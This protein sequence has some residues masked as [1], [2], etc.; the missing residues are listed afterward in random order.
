M[1]TCLLLTALLAPAASAPGQG[2][3]VFNNRLITGGP[4]GSLNEAFYAPIYGVN[5]ADPTS[6]RTGQGNAAGPG[7]LPIPLGT[8][9]YSGHPLLAGTGFTAQLW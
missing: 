8:T 2:Q 3:V 5:P 1:K 9:D 7:G 6:S 4:P